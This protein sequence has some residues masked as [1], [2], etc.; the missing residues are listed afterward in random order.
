MPALA[1]VV[2]D[3]D[4]EQLASFFRL[5][6]DRTR[7]NIVM[8]LSHGPRNVSSLC[9]ELHLPQ[10]TVSHHLGLLRTNNILVNRRQGKQV[11][12]AL[13]DTMDVSDGSIL[14]KSAGDLSVRIV[15]KIP[16][17]PA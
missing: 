6:S 16:S 9:E 11:F 3:H 8:A 13:V 12:Y 5:L 4:L 1:P 7:L 10:P 14:Q 2:K 15:K 17:A